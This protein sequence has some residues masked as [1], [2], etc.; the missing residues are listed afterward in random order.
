MVLIMEKKEMIKFENLSIS[1]KIAIIFAFICGILF[2]LTFLLGFIEGSISLKI[3]IIFAFICGIL[4]SL[5]FL[6][7]FIEG[8]FL[9]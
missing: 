5:T 4:L 2:S 1:L 6:L 3:A 9:G 7:G 8:F